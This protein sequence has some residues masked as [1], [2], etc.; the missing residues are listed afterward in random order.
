MLVTEGLALGQRRWNWA[1]VSE[2]LEDTIARG[3]VVDTAVGDLGLFR[4]TAGI[5]RACAA[6]WDAAWAHFET[7]LEQARDLPHMIEQAETRRWYGWALLE[8]G[9]AADAARARPMLEDA[10]ARYQ[11][12]G[13]RMHVDVAGR[14]LDRL[15]S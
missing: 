3:A 11:A 13:M 15:P 14:L 7:A 2:L 8:R 10:H 9:E 1:R 4:R 12:L 5:A 6:D